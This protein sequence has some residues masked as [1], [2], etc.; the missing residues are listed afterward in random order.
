MLFSGNFNDLPIQLNG[1]SFLL[2]S[3]SS[4]SFKVLPR[5]MGPAVWLVFTQQNKP[6]RDGFGMSHLS[7]GDLL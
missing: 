2:L 3:I 7:N 5:V 1:L 6:L 4:I